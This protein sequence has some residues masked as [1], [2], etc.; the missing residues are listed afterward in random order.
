MTVDNTG[1]KVTILGSG[2]C[3]PSLKRSSCSVLMQ[4]GNSRLL[5]DSG[6]G[7]MRRLLEAGTSIFDITHIFY[8]HFHP[9][10]TS[11]FVPFIFATKYPDGSRRKTPL[12]VGGGRGFL[13]FYEKLK[14]AYGSWIELAPELLN[15]IEFNNKKS[16]H[17]QFEDFAVETAPVAHN[18]ESIAYRITSADGYSA[19]YTGDTDHSETIIDLAQK[20]DVLICECAFPDKLR[21]PGHLTPSLAG[22]LAT[23]AEVRKLVLTHFYPECEKADI[24][25]ESRK[26]YSGP[27]VLA[28]DLMEIEIG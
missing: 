10:H 12:T 7:T 28:E 17:R 25:A 13:D 27:L 22:D 26:T 11:E 21:V 2:T 23:R 15:T 18:E 16:D 4:I 8:S 20:T 14:T 9:D 19:V 1:I 3:V 24:A 5:F 6:P